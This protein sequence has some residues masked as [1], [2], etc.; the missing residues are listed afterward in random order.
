MEDQ[1]KALSESQDH[2]QSS[3]TEAE[4]RAS[5][6]KDELSEASSAKD[7]LEKL[8]RREMADANLR[9]LGRWLFSSLNS[10]FNLIKIPAC[11]VILRVFYISLLFCLLESSTMYVLACLHVCCGLQSVPSKKLRRSSLMPWRK[12]RTLN[13][14]P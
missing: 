10:F 3:L 9:M 12:Q 13:I 2:L 6:L 8:L 4:L 1:L 14:R 11:K 7:E 5:T